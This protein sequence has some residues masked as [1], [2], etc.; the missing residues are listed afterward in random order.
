LQDLVNVVEALRPDIGGDKIIE[1]IENLLGKRG[2]ESAWLGEERG[3][4][5]ERTRLQRGEDGEERGDVPTP[6][7]LPV[8]CQN[9]TLSLPTQLPTR[10]RS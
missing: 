9:P 10:K 2:R 5:E 1:N 4:A 6:N 7:H 8:S 3:R